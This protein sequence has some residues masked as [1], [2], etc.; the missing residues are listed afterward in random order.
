MD[1]TPLLASTVLPFFLTLIM[2][3]LLIGFLNSK[4]LVVKDYHKSGS[5]MVPRPG[6]LAIFLGSVVPLFF[7][8][9]L[10]HNEGM[11]AL[12]L[13]TSIAFAVGLLDDFF[14]LGG[15]EKPLLLVLSALPILMLGAYDYHL[16]FPLFGAARL[17]IVYPILVLA[18]IPVVSNAVNMI[19][20]MNGVVSS[21]MIIATIPLAIFFALEGNQPMLL[22]SLV[23]ISTCIA[24][25]H[26]H[27][28]PSRIFPGD[29]G[30]LAL[31]AMY[32]AM[33]IVGRAEFVGMVALFPAVINSFS[34]LTSVKGFV[35]HR[36]VKERPVEVSGGMLRASKSLKA[37]ITL[38]RMIL[39]EG[40]LGER[41][42]AKNIAILTALSS[43]LAIL[44][45]LMI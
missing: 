5:R 35:E 12:A 2:T 41:D 43:A 6:G 40:P 26:Y 23:M 39:L 9:V 42:V 8:Y 18:A 16:H 34:Y 11:L 21:F 37:P 10:T 14:T 17:S 22:S 27:R 24:F 32:G 13:S 15:V 19:D 30:T 4:G 45:A 3:K 33:V 7:I 28:Y 31:G 38:V 1:L 44:T 20:V 25:Y 36:R 29:S